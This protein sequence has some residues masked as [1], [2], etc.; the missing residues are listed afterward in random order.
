MPLLSNQFFDLNQ[1]PQEEGILLWGI[2]M[3]RIGNTQSPAKNFE[4]LK[5][6]DKKIIKT[7]GI[8]MV[9]LYAD[10][11]YLNTN[12]PAYD[13][14]NAN[15]NLMI[16]HK[17][18]FLNLLSTDPAWVRKAFSF[19]TFGQMILDN[20]DV[21]KTALDKILGLY[22]TDA[23]FREAVEFDVTEAKKAKE[24]EYA[25]LFILEE[26]TFFYLSAKGK[27]SLQN[28]FIANP[29][30]VLQMYPGKPLKS[31]VLLFQLNPLKLSNP[32]NK[33]ENHY[34]DLE[35]KVLYDYSRLD[36]KTFNFE[37][38]CPYIPPII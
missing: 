34:Y 4:Y 11:L 2:S 38:K 22:K 16:D 37:E 10:Y 18:G 5:L 28:A 17:L 13:I 25:H 15:I 33:F 3:N 30:W 20:A 29:K 12:L 6:L 35:E 19:T 24:G 26:I 7:D 23:N 21:Y 31:E 32:D 8:G 27:L 1:F 9:N 14:K 36:I